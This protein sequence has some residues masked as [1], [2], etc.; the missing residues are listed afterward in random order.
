MNPM[1]D[2]MILRLSKERMERYSQDARS[3]RP[4]GRNGFLA[5]LRGWRW[6]HR[7]LFR[8]GQVLV[9]IG[10]QMENLATG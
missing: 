1:P 9:Q 6:A 8:I 4:A 10:S 2:L 5:S 7:P 3:T